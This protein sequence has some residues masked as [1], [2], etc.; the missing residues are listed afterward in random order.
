MVVIVWRESKLEQLTVE[1]DESLAVGFFSLPE[2]ESQLNP[3]QIAKL[4]QKLVSN[5][6]LQSLLKTYFRELN[7]W[8]PIEALSLKQGEQIMQMGQ[9]S[10]QRHSHKSF[11]LSSSH[12]TQLD[13]QT[14]SLLSVRQNQLL[15][16]MHNLAKPFISNA[17]E[18]HQVK[19]L[20]LQDHLTGLANRASFDKCLGQLI[21]SAKRTSQVFGLLVIDLDNFKQVNDKLGHGEGD[22]VLSQIG[23]ILEHAIRESDHGFR[24]GGDEFA[25]LLP[26]ADSQTNQQIAHRIQSATAQDP[27][28]NK[29]GVSCS[30]GS[31]SFSKDDDGQSLFTRA[32]QALYRA[33]AAGRNC[34]MAA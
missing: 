5:L 28:L 9:F 6:D 3:L 14:A 34:I 7:S 22:R 11:R 27:L 31:A 17:L 12:N 33:K 4:M 8:L 21:S 2:Q 32:D 29:Y 10:A 16:E 13:Y 19:Q 25:C 20:A 30:I 18:H 26:N 24:F 15:Q 1:Y 23:N